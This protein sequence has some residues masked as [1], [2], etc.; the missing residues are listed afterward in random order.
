MKNQ[1]I[2]GMVIAVS[3]SSAQA[4]V[5][6]ICDLAKTPVD[7]ATAGRVSSSQLKSY[8]EKLNKECEL[9]SKYKT[10]NEKL[11]SKHQISLTD[12]SEYQAIRF[13]QRSWL[14]EAASL[15]KPVEVIYQILKDQYLLPVSQQSGAIWD[16]WAVGIQQLEPL[17][18]SFKSGKSFDLAA[19]KKIHRGLFP[20]Y[21]LVD[22]HGDFAHEP[23]PGVLKPTI[24][25]AIDTYWWELAPA[26][27][28]SAQETVKNENVHYKR[29]GLLTEAPKGLPE[30]VSHIL[31]VRVVEK[32]GDSSQK[33][34]A[35]F[36]GSNVV[37]RQNTELILS[38]VDK[39]MQKARAGQH[40]L[41]GDQLLTPGEMAYLLQQAYVRIHP[42][43]EGN[44][45]TSRF[46]QE[47]IL[48][49]FNLPHGASGDLMDS[50][51][52]DESGIYYQKAMQANLALIEKM[53]QCSDEY[54]QVARKKDVRTLDQSQLS[55]GCRILQDRSAIWADFKKK[56]EVENKD[57]YEQRVN[58]LDRLDRQTDQIHKM[59][60]DRRSG[61]IVAVPTPA[62]VAVDPS[63]ECNDKSGAEK[64]RC[65]RFAEIRKRIGK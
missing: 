22:E 37:N 45:R 13:V 8:Q 19:L 2:L 59:E 46:L 58:A 21:P 17:I 38:T 48:L 41:L 35:L 55:Y 34:T 30:Y 12:I 9:S 29:L 64:Q 60:M 7:A 15:G 57:K 5:L 33:V 51:A 44:G 24:S 18:E 23:N 11:R 31:D 54:D 42:F 28:S 40:L 63:L 49:S 3:M 47:L 1:L 4:S 25:T 10:L 32:R 26:D 56:N 14:N 16:D 62:I 50:D 61:K 53:N 43:Y 39:L 6:D 27:I 20:F 65:E 36:S 52:L